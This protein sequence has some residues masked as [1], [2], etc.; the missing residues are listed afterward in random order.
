MNTTALWPIALGAFEALGEHYA[1][2]MD[3]AATEMG[4][5]GWYGGWLLPAWWA[6]PEPISSTRLRLRSPYTSTRYYNERLARAAR[7]GFLTPTAEA[8]NE[9][10]L[11]ELGRQAA[12][13]MMEAMYAKMAGLQPLSSTDL[14]RLARLLHRLVMSCLAVPEPPG[15]LAILTSRRIDPGDDVSVVV[16][17]D[18]YGGDLAAYRDDAH[19]AA[20]QPYNIACHAWEAFSLLWCGEANSLD[21]LYKKLERRGYWLDEYRQALEDL[22]QRGWV[23]EDVGGYRVTV[24]GREIRQAAEEATDQY[25]YAPWSCLNLDETEELRVLLLSLC[26]GL[27]LDS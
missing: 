22:I 9:Y 6:E 15:K 2:D 20:W 21:G 1:P 7:H 10:R 11:T 17:I 16:R 27:R 25:F 8:E 23:R 3:Q 13:H 24:L 14:E 5:S 12:I 4:L 19:L 18:Q 26:D